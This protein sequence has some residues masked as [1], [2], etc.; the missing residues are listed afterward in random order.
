MKNWAE[1]LRKA[2]EQRGLSR[3]EL[4]DKAYT[5]YSN[6]RAYEI[7]KRCMSITVVEHLFDALGFELELR[8][9]DNN[10]E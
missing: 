6:I 9:G 2:R 8:C 10:D 3:Q 7:G 5:T 4:A 1:E